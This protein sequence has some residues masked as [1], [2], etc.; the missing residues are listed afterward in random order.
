[1]VETKFQTSFIP[2]QPVTGETERRRGGVGVLFLISFL[3]MVASAAAAVGVFIWNKTTLAQIE[4]GKIQLEDH[5]NAFDSNSI[6]E[7]TRLDNRIDVASMLLKSHM[8]A[9][10]IFPRLQDNTLR[11]VRFNNFT[12]SNGGNGK[13]LISMSGVAQD[14]ESMALQAQQFTKPE[15]QNAFRSPIFSNF[16]KERDAVVFTFGSGIDPY[17]V[18]YYQNRIN[19]AKQAGLTPTAP[20]NTQPNQ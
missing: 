7:F 18:E 9:S 3:L 5:K 8:G 2:K 16:S 4:K 15:L 17:V 13:I 11:T 10:A 19:A 20:A 6:N 12:Y 14:Y 1:M